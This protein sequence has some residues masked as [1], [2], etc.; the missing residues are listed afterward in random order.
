V[1]GAADIRARFIDAAA[2]ARQAVLAG[3]PGRLFKLN[4]AQRHAANRAAAAAVASGLAH[5]T[6]IAKFA[7]LTNQFRGAKSARKAVRIP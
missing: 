2:F 3:D 1:K 4:D 6:G 7:P 5:R